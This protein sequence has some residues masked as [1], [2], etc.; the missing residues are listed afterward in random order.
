MSI[1]CFFSLCKEDPT[2]VIIAGAG[3]VVV[4]ILIITLSSILCL[5]L[6]TYRHKN[7]AMLGI[8]N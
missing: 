2:T 8:V 7:K 3:A 1:E 6:M 4:I 5:T